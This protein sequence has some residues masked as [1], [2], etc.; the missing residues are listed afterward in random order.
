MQWATAF[1]TNH[2]Q[3]DAIDA[4]W[5]ENA[6]YCFLQKSSQFSYGDLLLCTELNISVTNGFLTN[7]E[8]LKLCISNTFQVSDPL[9]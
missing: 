1:Y 6:N 3:D 9:K 4:R 2:S 5:S 7:T 8:T